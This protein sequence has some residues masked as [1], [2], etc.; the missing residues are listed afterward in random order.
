MRT[1]GGMMELEKYWCKMSNG[2][3][4]SDYIAWLLAHDYGLAPEETLKYERV[5][6]TDNIGS[7][8]LAN[9]DNTVKIHVQ[10]DI[11]KLEKQ[12]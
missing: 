5:L 1:I 4:Y 3:P 8:F 2:T 6:P 10:Y 11:T 7:T 12:E 9:T